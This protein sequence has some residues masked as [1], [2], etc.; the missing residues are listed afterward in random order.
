MT[1]FVFALCPAL[2]DDI[3]FNFMKK[4]IGAIEGRGMYASLVLFWICSLVLFVPVCTCLYTGADLDLHLFTQLN[5][6]VCSYCVC[7]SVCVLAHVCILHRYMH[8][9]YFDNYQSDDVIVGINHDRESASVVMIV[10]FAMAVGL[11]QRSAVSV[12]LLWCHCHWRTPSWNVPISGGA[13]D[14]FNHLP[15]MEKIHKSNTV[16]KMWVVDSLLF[17][18]T[19]CPFLGAL[20]QCQWRMHDSCSLDQWTSQDI[21]HSCWT[22]VQ[23]VFTCKYF[24]TDFRFV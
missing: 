17:E 5:A 22:E 4:G 1:C 16:Q 24:E 10:K 11:F 15:D 7:V 6:Y 21:G 9:L 14:I 23:H 20:W 3:G 2:L 13:S 19:N 18:W 12:V 8:T